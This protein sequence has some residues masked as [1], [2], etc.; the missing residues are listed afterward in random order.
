[1]MHFEASADD[2]DGAGNRQTQVS[3]L[4]LNDVGKKSHTRKD[5]GLAIIPST[6]MVGG[7]N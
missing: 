7:G 3:V 5:L 4:F 1:M 6:L 2:N